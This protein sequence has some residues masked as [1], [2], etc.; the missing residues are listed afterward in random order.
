MKSNRTSRPF[1]CD[2]VSIGG[3]DSLNYTQHSRLIL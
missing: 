2:V 3:K 1:D